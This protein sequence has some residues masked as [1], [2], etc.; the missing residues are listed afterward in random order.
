MHKC[1][2]RE[3]GKLYMKKLLSFITVM[4]MIFC[5]MPPVRSFATDKRTVEYTDYVSVGNNKFIPQ[6]K[7]AECTVIDSANIISDLS[8]GWYF[9]DGD[10]AFSD[11]IEING[12]VHLILSAG[13]TL[14]AY[15]G[16]GDF[17]FYITGGNLFPVRFGLQAF[18]R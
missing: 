13:Y 9:A 10:F 7:T 8:T 15:Y 4:A 12:D 18:F 16:S 14:N 17:F 3:E 1:E 5:F 6:T 2:K 11:R